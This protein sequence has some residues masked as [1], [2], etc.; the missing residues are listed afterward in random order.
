MSAYHVVGIG[1]ILWDFLPTGSQ[2]GGAPCSVAFH[3]NA[4]GDKGTI[5]SRV[6]ADALGE[7]AVKLVGRAGV[8]VSHVQR[9]ADAPTGT[10]SVSL[11]R[12]GQ[13]NFL[14]TPDV[15]WDRMEWTDEWLGV[16]RS[17]DAVCF[18]TLAQRS[19]R[20]RETIRS[21]VGAARPECL[22]AF[23]VNLRQFFYTSEIIRAS[24]ELAT[25]CKMN[26][27]ELPTVAATLRIPVTNALDT[28]RRILEE[29]DLRCVA[30]TRGEKG[31]LLVSEDDVAEH[32][33]FQVEIQDTVGA[34]DAFTAGL[35]HSLLRGM[36][37]ADA[38]QVA[39][40]RG[41]WV[42]ASKGAMPDPAT[43]DRAVLG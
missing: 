13:P 22:V 2:L 31:S 21:F 9:D 8:D 16:A 4:L 40:E 3:A 7:T 38:S 30:L 10:V 34:G 26:E 43:F 25:V 23:D 32:P 42:A 33:G 19:Q 41:A 29:F 28:A 39:A 27:Q 20:S 6:G 15:A 5:L 17:A 1:E 12:R 37:L 18:G 36:T 35:I 14:I 11:N 24:L